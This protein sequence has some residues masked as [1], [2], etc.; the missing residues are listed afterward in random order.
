MG[1][2]EPVERYYSV[3][4]RRLGEFCWVRTIK[5]II[6]EIK[7]KIKLCNQLIVN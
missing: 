4:K 1:K 7:F 3:F 5:N 2:R 6:Q